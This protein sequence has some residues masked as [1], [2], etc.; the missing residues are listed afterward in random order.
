MRVTPS[1]TADN[2]L[3][4]LQQGRSR[5]DRLN[6]Q[7]SSGMNILRPSDDPITTRQIMDLENK[8]KE[9]EQYISNITKANLWLDVTDTTLTGIADIAKAIKNVSSNITSGTT[10]SSIRATA[11]S[12]LKEFRNQLSSLANTQLG[13][14]YIFG[15]YK[16]ATFHA[17][18]VV[19]SATTVTLDPES[20][21][22][23]SVGMSVAV[24][25]TSAGTITAIDGITNTVTVNGII[26]AAG[27]QWLSFGPPYNGAPFSVKE[28]SGTLNGTPNVVLSDISGLSVGMPVGGAGIPDN[29]TITAID[30]ATNTVTL[31]NNATV[32]VSGN[33]VALLFGGNYRGT[34]NEIGV[35][36]SRSSTV[37]I[38]IVGGQLFN[39]TGDYGTVDMF[40]A[41]DGLITSITANNVASIRANAT[42]FDRSTQQ[43]QN[44]QSDVAGRMTRLESANNMLVRDQNTAKGIIS[45]RQNVDYA[46]AA[47]ELNQQQIAF[48][49]A[50]SATAKISQLSLLDYI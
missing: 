4:N 28:A 27:T 34:D 40:A 12:Q 9:S 13:D 41:L 36:V 38:N 46:K 25:G 10:D 33:P 49:A 31:N 45:D 2:A 22:N 24:A 3:Y 8:V 39:G 19:A 30:G 17:E 44:A 23:L 42:E 47:T 16:N 6:E 37:G 15:G 18:G 5:L 21:A 14:Q 43:I 7:I 1:I 11:V 26:T 29:T 20:L 35:A 48:E 32:P 50:L